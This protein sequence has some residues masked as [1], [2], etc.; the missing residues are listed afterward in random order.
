M[1]ENSGTT[2]SLHLQIFLF[3]MEGGAKEIDLRT[4]EQLP[5]DQNQLVW[6][7][8]DYSKKDTMAWL[9]NITWL[10]PVI[11]ANLLDDDTRPRSFL[12]QDGL[13]LS[14]RGV[15]LNPGADP[16]DMIAV[17]MWA[18]GKLILTSNRR[19][20]LSLEDV[21]EQLRNGRGPDSAGSFIRLLIERLAARAEGVIEQ[22]EESFED[23]EENMEQLDY[24]EQ[25]TTLSDYRRQAIRIKRYFTPQKEALQQLL[26]ESPVW[27][28]KREKVHIRESLNKFRRYLEELDTLRD[29]AIVAQ[30]ELLGK[31]SEILNKRMFT[32]SLVATFFLPLGFLTGL[33]GINVGGIPGSESTYGFGLT[34]LGI[35]LLVLIMAGYLK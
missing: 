14:L 28:S 9:Q 34:C 23:F 11:Q 24:T 7:H 18:T 20:L 16:E 17:R 31:F 30:E 27:V 35:I 33:L 13:F 15:N 19:K 32:L 21:A 8:V 2:L 25:R 4:F 22:L 5:D 10:D 12:L 29:R 1:T 3:D 6:I 26:S